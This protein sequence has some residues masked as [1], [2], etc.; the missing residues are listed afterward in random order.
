MRLVLF[1][2]G[3]TEKSS[4][5]DF[6]K[7]GL[8]PKLPQPIGITIVSFNGVGEY[9]SKIRNRV[10]L[11]LSGKQGKEVIAAVGIID[12]YGPTIFPSKLAPP[13]KSIWGKRMLEEQ[14]GHPKFRQ[15]FAVHETEA[16]LLAHKEIL[17]RAIMERLPGRCSQP[18]LVDSKQPPSKLLR[19]L[20]QRYLNRPYLKIIDGENLFRR[21]DPNIVAAK[22]PHFAQML[23]D[24]EQLARAALE[25]DR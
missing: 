18:E 7:R 17:P 8:D 19:R 4:I 2:E 5:G 16:W 1:V 10:W 13:E 25:K 14:V 21:C 9:L 15:Y 22:C 12:L 6:I 23:K 11:Y 3:Q 24:L 20:Y